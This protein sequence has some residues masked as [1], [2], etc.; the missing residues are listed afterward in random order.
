MGVVVNVQKL[1][2][3]K[4]H[5]LGW[6]DISDFGGPRVPMSQFRVFGHFGRSL[7]VSPFHVV[8]PTKAIAAQ[9]A[10]KFRLFEGIP[11][12]KLPA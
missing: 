3:P 8:K 1:I 10:P 5:P 11:H 9:S 6:W 4:S 12:D 7:R 2:V